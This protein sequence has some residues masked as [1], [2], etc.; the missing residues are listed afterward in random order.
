MPTEQINT[1]SPRRV[2]S[3]V[4]LLF[5]LWALIL[6]NVRLVPDGTVGV[7]VSIAGGIVL[8]IAIASPFEWFVHRYIYHRTQPGPLRQIYNIHQSHHYHIFPIWRYTTNGPVRRHPVMQSDVTELRLAGWKNAFTKMAHFSI[9]MV[10]GFLFI[11]M[12]AWLITGNKWFLGS[13]IITSAI[14]SDLFVRVHD[15]I[16]Y[17][18]LH[19]LTQK[20]RWFKFLD[21]HHY[22]HHIDTNA[23][24]NFLLPLA[25][26]LFGTLRLKATPEELAQFG[27]LKE[28]RR[29]PLGMSEP[30]H[31]VAK[32]KK[33]AK[34]AA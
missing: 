28:V 32:P 30:A 4:I 26:S 2:V 22:I 5:G 17:P 10:L 18:D 21:N 25:D 3:A 7:L 19:P 9:Y 13:I 20:L 29:N 24:V 31:L 16:H 12:P 1:L 6:I 27:T 34:V 11:W 14:V 8:T 15:A 23:N 33:T